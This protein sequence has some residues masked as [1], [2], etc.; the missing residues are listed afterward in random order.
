RESPERPDRAEAPEAVAGVVT[1][2]KTRRAGGAR[3]EHL[4][5]RVVTEDLDAG[6]SELRTERGLRAE[7]ELAAG[8]RH[9]A[10]GRR[11]VRRVGVA[12]DVAERAQRDLSVLVQVL[13][14]DEADTLVARRRVDLDRDAAAG[15]DRPVQDDGRWR[16]DR[17][18]GEGRDDGA[19]LTHEIGLLVLVRV[20]ETERPVR[21]ARGVARADEREAEVPGESRGE[22]V[23]VLSGA[24]DGRAHGV[25]LVRGEVSADSE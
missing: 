15:W 1:E 18:V 16:R 25:V 19:D 13:P 21:V 11:V 5:R 2:A 10:V 24:G 6:A 3:R 22:R 20:A 9:R 7:V 4:V 12:I 17:Y 8:D 14:R 23:R